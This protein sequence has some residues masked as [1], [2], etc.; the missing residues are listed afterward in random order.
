MNPPA[1]LVFLF[2]GFLISF[3]A[4]SDDSVIDRS[5]SNEPNSLYM[6]EGEGSDAVVPNDVL[7]H[8][9]DGSDAWDSHEYQD[10]GVIDNWE[11]DFDQDCPLNEVC[12][13][14]ICFEDVPNEGSDDFI[15][16]NLPLCD[17]E[18]DGFRFQGV[19]DETGYCNC[20]RC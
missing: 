1:L 14:Y 7:D 5:V 19:R 8:F 15:P 20:S 12:I 10:D 16:V 13:D 3:V 2:S 18:E 6:A 4:I 9:N 17:C 11:C